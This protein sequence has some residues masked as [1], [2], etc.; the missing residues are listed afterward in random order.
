MSGV[1][2]DLAGA[3]DNDVQGNDIGTDATGKIALGNKIDGVFILTGA[4]NP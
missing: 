1:V 4:S 2:L 3:T